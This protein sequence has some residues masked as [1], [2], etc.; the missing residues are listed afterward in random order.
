MGIAFIGMIVA[1]VLILVAFFGPWYAASESIEGFSYESSMSLTSITT[2]MGGSETTIQIGD[3]PDSDAKSV[4]NN[5]YYMS[6]LAVIFAILALIGIL[7]VTFNFGPANLMSKLG[8]IFG[9]LTFIFAIIAVFYFMSAL[10]GATP[11]MDGFWVEGAGPGYAWYL[12]LIAG[13]IGLIASIPTF[14]K[15]VA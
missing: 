10:P 13:I 1:L 12:M 6:I 9:I 8:G 3:M 2:K 7:G 15:Q 14:K 5:T 4:I 11:G